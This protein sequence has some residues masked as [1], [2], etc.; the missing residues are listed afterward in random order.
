MEELGA[1]RIPSDANKRSNAPLSA[2][3]NPV[4][5]EPPNTLSLEQPKL[6]ARMPATASEAPE[7]A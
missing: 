3:V 2:V 5:V 6:G 4:R 1:G 7:E